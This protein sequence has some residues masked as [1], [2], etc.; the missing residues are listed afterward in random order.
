M[1][2]S[3]RSRL[4]NEAE[5]TVSLARLQ[6]LAQSVGMTPL[7]L[8]GFLVRASQDSPQVPRFPWFR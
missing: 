2:P 5:E 8:Q 4:Q 7:R 6:A 1:E 3:N